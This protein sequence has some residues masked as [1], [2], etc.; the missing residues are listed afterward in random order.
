[1]K[2]LEMINLEKLETEGCIAYEVNVEES[3]NDLDMF[4]RLSERKQNQ[5]KKV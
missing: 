1:M 2:N 3:D 4:L 5:K